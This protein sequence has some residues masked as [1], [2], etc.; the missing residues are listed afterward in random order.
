MSFSGA[1]DDGTLIA[2]GFF[3]CYNKTGWIWRAAVSFDAFH[4]IMTGKLLWSKVRN[5]RAKETGVRLWR[6]CRFQHPATGA[7]AARK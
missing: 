1:I 4:P 7:M 3:V 6:K 2:R 5:C